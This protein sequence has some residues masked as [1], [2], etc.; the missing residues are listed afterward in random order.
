MSRKGFIV[1]RQRAIVKE[2]GIY[3]DYILKTYLAIK[4][5][6]NDKEMI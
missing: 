5:T 4:I 3:Q 2:A 1:N 6:K